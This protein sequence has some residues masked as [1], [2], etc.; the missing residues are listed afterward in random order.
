[1]SGLDDGFFAKLLP[2]D[3]R[4]FVGWRKGED[5][6]S[7][8]KED[9]LRDWWLTVLHLLS[10]QHFD[11]EKVRSLLERRATTPLSDHS[12]ALS[13]PWTASS[14]KEYLASRGPEAI[15]EVDRWVES[16]RFGDPY[17][18]PLAP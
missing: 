11:D 16:F 7:R 13:P 3:R 8:A 1:M 17:A 9:V 14:L 10:F 6:L 18:R 5:A 2:E 15:R 12:F 4:I